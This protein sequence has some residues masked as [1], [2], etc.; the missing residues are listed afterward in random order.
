[1]QQDLQYRLRAPGDGELS[2]VEYLAADG[3]ETAALVTRRARRFGHAD[4][5]LP[6]RALAPDA[7]YRDADTGALHHG[8][9]LLSHGLPLRLAPGDN[10][11]A[12]VHLVR[13]D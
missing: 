1:M 5:A 13:E 12:L 8:A 2:A 10:A 11:S 7:R 3:S 4:S 6:L 9:V